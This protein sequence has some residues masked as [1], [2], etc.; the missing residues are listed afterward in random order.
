MRDC[1]RHGPVRSDIH[2]GLEAEQTFD[3][4][5]RFDIIPGTDIGDI[6]SVTFQIMNHRRGIGATHAQR[7]V[8]KAVVARC[9]E[10]VHQVDVG[11]LYGVGQV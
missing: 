8:D 6:V 9:G 3:G 1:A 5:R 7:D 10:E 11:I 4:Y 2:Q